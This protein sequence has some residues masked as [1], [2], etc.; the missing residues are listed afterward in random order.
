VI[1]NLHSI[2]VLEL[3]NVTH[4]ETETGRRGRGVQVSYVVVE[5]ANANAVV[6]EDGIE[7]KLAVF[8]VAVRSASEHAVYHFRLEV[9]VL[10]FGELATTLDLEGVWIG[11]LLCTHL[12]N[13]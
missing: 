13:L 3:L 4:S 2:L 6:G 9:S 1:A 11:R 10:D 12:G 7:N 8:V 5:G